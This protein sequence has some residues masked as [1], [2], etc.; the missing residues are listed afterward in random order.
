MPPSAYRLATI[1][2]WA[3]RLIGMFPARSGIDPDILKL[4]I[5]VRTIRRSGMRRGSC[6]G[7]PCSGYSRGELQPPDR[8]RISGLFDPAA[9]HRILCGPG[10]PVCVLGD[11]M[12][13]IF[14]WQG[15][16]LADW[17]KHVCTHFPLAGEL[18]NAMALEERITEVL[19]AG[20]STCARRCGAAWRLI[21][22]QR[23]LK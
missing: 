20:C 21:C 19:A 1:D 14:G 13:A 3:M 16:E 4:E 15:N 2:G 17:D 7:R 5:H 23:R 10:L 8:R 18:D 22:V 12:Q 11:P 9:R 6:S